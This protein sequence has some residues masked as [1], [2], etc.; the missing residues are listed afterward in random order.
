MPA[1]GELKMQHV[2]E[3]S[4]LLGCYYFGH[5]FC[6]VVLPTHLAIID[7][8]LISFPLDPKVRHGKVANLAEAPSLG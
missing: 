6:G 7:C 4:D 8:A 3:A 5:H 1:F 2:T